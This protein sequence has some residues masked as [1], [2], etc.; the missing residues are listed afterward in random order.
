MFICII[1]CTPHQPLKDSG[2]RERGEGEGGGCQRGEE[3]G[4]GGNGLIV[5]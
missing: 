3:R 1:T 5:S 2:E 4:G